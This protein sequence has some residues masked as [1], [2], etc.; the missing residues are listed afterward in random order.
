LLCLINL[1]FLI[2]ERPKLGNC[3]LR[4]L[5]HDITQI[6]LS[7]LPEIDYDTI[8]YEW[9]HPKIEMLIITPD[10]HSFIEAATPLIEWKNEKGV[11]TIILSNF[12]SYEGRDK[13]EKIRNMIKSYY[14]TENIQWV[15]LAGDATEDLLPTRYVYNPDTVEYSGS[16]YN[17]YNEYYKPTDFYYADLTGSWDEDGDGKWGE[18]SRYNS[19]G[20]DEIDWDPEVYVGRIPASNAEE[21]EIMVN[22]TINYEKNPSIGDWMNSMLLAGG[23]SDYSPAEDETRLT[24]HIIQNYVQSEMNYTHLCEYTSSYTPPDPKEPLTQNNYVNYF[25]SG[26]STVFFAGHGNPFKFIRNPSNDVAY[27]SNN[28]IISNNSNMPSLIYAFAC[29]TSPIDQNNNNIGEILIKRNNS[30]AIGY[31][32]GMRITWYFEHDTKLEKLNRGNAKLF[33]KE[34]FTEKKYQQGQALYDSKVAYMNSDYFDNPSVSMRLEYERK[35]VL[36][37]CLLGDPQLEIYTNKPAVVLNP[38]DKKIY[39]GQNITL[40]I[41]NIYNESIPNARICITSD[42]KLYRTLY[43]DN[44]GNCNFVIPA[45]KDKEYEIV[46]TGHNLIP[47]HFNFTTRLDTIKPEINILNISQENSNGIDTIYFIIEAYDLYSGIENVFILLSKNN[48]EDF[49]ILPMEKNGLDENYIYKLYCSNLLPGKYLYS[50]I[51]RD[52]ANNTS[53]I[54]DIGFNFEII[55]ENQ[56]DNKSYIYFLI[57]SSII[58]LIGISI[59]LIYRNYRRKIV[60][61]REWELTA[62]KIRKK[63]RMDNLRKKKKLN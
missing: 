15:L 11:K 35:N 50:A 58:G 41:R 51:A 62:V 48:F 53:I 33:W 42:N 10:N 20:K 54:Y 21:L 31:I 57:I 59:F 1:I 7:K 30:G 12:S 4:L 16:E 9:Y 39:E 38:F 40:N 28:A 8:Y 5:Q 13:A 22:K 17:G 44:E 18:S 14:L 19:H 37:Y 60:K 47:S 26:F 23:I 3:E 49:L 27:T 29:T 25:N 45:L 6:D 32:G 24:T 55:D 52:F 43:A 46:I 63:E 34:F 2:D 36:T 61:K 56:R